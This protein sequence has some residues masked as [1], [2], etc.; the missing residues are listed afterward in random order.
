VGIYAEDIDKRAYFLL[1]SELE[2]ESFP[3][4]RGTE[5]FVSFDRQLAMH[6][7]D[8]EFLSWDHPMVS[9]AI[10]MILGREK[11]NCAYAVWQSQDSPAI[12]L[13]AIFV[14]ECIA[15]PDLHLDRFLPA[16]P[17]RVLVNHDLADLSADY[18]YEFMKR[19][20]KD[21][22]GEKLLQNP[23]FTQSLFPKMLAYCQELASNQSVL[24]REAGRRQM[25]ALLKNELQRLSALKAVNPAV[26]E[27]EIEMAHQEI[28]SLDEAI[29]SAQLR[30]DA[31]R[32]I[33]KK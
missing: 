14:L 8:I 18:P 27:E 33:W 31:L 29:S 22:D 23:Q 5:M 7:E 24:I 17:I 26:K 16:T 12:L 11:G 20:L 15:P 9:G 4:F 32:L 21:D 25:T 1:A 28:K 19:H 30:L 2:L 3:G 13:E 10:D 6:R